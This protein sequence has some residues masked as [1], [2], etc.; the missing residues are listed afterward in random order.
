MAEFEDKVKA[1]FDAEFERTRARPGLRGRVIANAVATP[2]TSQ[3]FG[4]WL[5]PRRLATVAAAAA[6]LVV[7]G[8]GIR[9]ATQGAPSTARTSPTPAAAQLAFGKLPPPGL[10]PPS[11]LGSGGGGTPTTQPYFG[12]A[13]LSWS[14]QLPKMPSSAPVYRFSLPTTADEDAF[15]TRLGAKLRSAGSAIASRS[16]QGPDGYTMDISEDPGAGE[17]GFIMN[18]DQGPNPRPPLTE[19]GARPAAGAELTRL[20]LTPSWKFAV[21]VSQFTPSGESAPIF[22]VQYQRLIQVSSTVTAGEV[23]GN[24]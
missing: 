12:P 19:D 10:R 7:A 3:G 1:A 18:R 8:V 14:G 2:T 11:G 15:A 17:R 5:A 9:I 24:G 22:V 4:P 6:L 23:D 21:Q 20:T 13:K 16:Y